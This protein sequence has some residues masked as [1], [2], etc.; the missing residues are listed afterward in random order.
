MAESATPALAPSTA[1]VQASR[2]RRI[3]RRLLAPA[4]YARRRPF[5][6]LAWLLAIGVAVLAAAAVALAGIFQYHLRAARAE[7][8]RG[9]NAGALHH[10]EWCRWVR[11]GGRDVLILSARVARRFGSWDEADELLTRYWERYGDEEPLVFERLLHRAAR[12]DLEGA[13]A[14]LRP[15]IDRGGP[16]ARL[17]REALVAG[18]SHRFRLADARAVVDAWIAADPDD[19]LASLLSGKLYEQQLA[20]EEAVQA[21]RRAIELDPEQHDARLRLASLLVGR[22]RGEEAEAVL[23][24]L[25]AALPDHPEA[26]VLRVRTLALLGRTSEARAALEA[27]LRAHPEYPPALFERGNS[28]LSDGDGPAAERDLARAAALDPGN[29]QIRN[30]YALAL[31]RN[32]KSADAAKQHAAVKQLQE[33]AERM[34]FLIGG[35]LQARPNDPALHHEIGT[36][37]L[38]SGLVPDAIRWFTS[39]LQVDPNYLPTHRA[40]AG[41]YQQ[42]DNPVLAARHRAMAQRLAT[43]APKP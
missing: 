6:A 21:Y 15:R 39:A 22:R 35:P 1:P 37:A 27:C 20:E 24:P 5:R 16:E 29:I 43:T 25:L 4:R 14:T 13:A 11:P 30:Q 18:L 2:A 8:D 10:L 40:L 3:L 12:G 28:A 32:G 38:R 19:A 31:A 42:L 33:D 34:T 17:A 23:G 26:Q 36:I 41:L 9:H 7:L